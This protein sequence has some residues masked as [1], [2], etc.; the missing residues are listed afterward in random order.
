MLKRNQ[1]KGKN[2]FLISAVAVKQ[3][4]KILV[5]SSTSNQVTFPS[6]RGHGIHPIV[7]SINREAGKITKLIKIIR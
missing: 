5:T 1:L 7:D 2:I 4:V 6:Y 3:K